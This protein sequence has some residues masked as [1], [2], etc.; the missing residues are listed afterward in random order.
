MKIVHFTEE[1]IPQA[2]M[3]VHEGYQ[4]L[5]HQLP[6]FRQEIELPSMLSLVQ[7]GLGV[8]AV[9]GEELLGFLSCYMAFPDAF[10]TT[11]VKGIFCPLHGHGLQRGQ[12]TRLFE[13]LYQAAAA[14]WVEQGILSHAICLYEYEKELQE[15]FFMNGFGVRCMD[16]ARE[17]TPIPLSHSKLASYRPLHHE[18]L[19]I[20][21]PMNNSLILHLG[22][23]PV[24]MKFPPMTEEEFLKKNSEYFFYVAEVA[25]QPVAYLRFGPEGENFACN[26][27]PMIHCIGAYAL[28]DYRGHGLMDDLLS[29]AAD[30][31]RQKGFTLMGVDC[32][33]LN[34]NARFYWQKHFVPYTYSLVRRIDDKAVQNIK[35]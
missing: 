29:F 26:A 27:Q 31:L 14:K 19:A 34:P 10:H 28:P 1:W 23:S 16:L 5:R 7:H 33:S 3:L 30:D 4:Q 25:N 12:S 17:N 32:E 21:L 6:W 2:Q 35:E 8:A 24:F 18:E 13:K 20:L 22:S 15:L 9:E 11:G